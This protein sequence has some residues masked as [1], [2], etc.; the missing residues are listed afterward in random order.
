MVR[1]VLGRLANAVLVVAAMSLFVF[2]L[3]R[4]APG[5]PVSYL[6]GEF[7][8]P[9]EIAEVTASL[10]LDR[11]LVDQYVTFAGGLL[12]GDFGRSTIYKTSAL[13]LVLERMPATIELT[14]V[15]MLLAMVIAIPMG[16]VLAL[17]RGTWLDHGGSVIGV[18]GVSIPNFWLGFMLILIFS[19]TLGWTATSGRSGPLTDA[20]IHALSGDP[21][22]LGEAMRHIALPAI[23][24]CSFQLAYISRITR[25]TLLEELGQNYVRAARARGLP[26]VL[27]VGK[28]ALRNAVLP[29]L[30]VL[31]LELGS[32]IGGAV[33]TESVFSWPGIGFLMNE[34][35]SGRDYP[36]AQAAILVTGMVVILVTLVVDVLYGVADPRIRYS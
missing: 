28:H 21:R 23:T 36:L 13:E 6:V 25:S 3:L 32:L 18:L 30:T 19:V 29:I 22:A 8:T 24:L 5:S 9:E 1:F 14:L 27:V 16:I 15:A 12:Q 7:A 26:P 4:L 11:S 20:I 33:V 2:L 17:R 10:G 34:A 35:I 31:G